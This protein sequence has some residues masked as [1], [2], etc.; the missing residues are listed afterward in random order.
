MTSS[1]KKSAA[2]NDV[3]EDWAEFIF[4]N[5][6]GGILNTWTQWLFL[7][8]V[9]SS[10]PLL[11]FIRQDRGH[12]KSSNM[13]G[14]KPDPKGKC[15]LGHCRLDLLGQI[16]VLVTCSWCEM[17]REYIGAWLKSSVSWLSGHLF[18]VS[19]EEIY[20][21]LLFR[22]LETSKV[23]K[24]TLGSSLQAWHPRLTY[25]KMADNHCH[26]VLSVLSCKQNSI[27]SEKCIEYGQWR[28]SDP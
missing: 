15:Y 17:Q 23:N 28:H 3:I 27:N 11:D 5:W 8:F 9:W 10:R 20:L 7:A 19:K 4:G 18:F 13:F 16:F 14:R 26:L 6:H 24:T 22:N 25:E 21:N 12:T 2:G 1:V